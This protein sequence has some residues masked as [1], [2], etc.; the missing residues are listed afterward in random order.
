MASIARVTPSAPPA[1][2]LNRSKSSRR[3]SNAATT[4]L[5]RRLR[6]LPAQLLRSATNSS[7]LAPAPRAQR[8]LRLRRSTHPAVL[9]SLSPPSP[10]PASPRNTAGTSPSYGFLVSFDK[11][12]NIASADGELIAISVG[13]FAVAAT[14]RTPRPPPGDLRQYPPAAPLPELQPARCI[15][16]AARF[17]CFDKYR[18]DRTPNHSAPTPI[19]TMPAVCSTTF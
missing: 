4:E 18:E 19:P 1:P 13:R 8:I 3:F 5:S 7:P 10:G 17:H 6:R 12:P 2:A 15:L 11:L 9:S 16:L 14:A